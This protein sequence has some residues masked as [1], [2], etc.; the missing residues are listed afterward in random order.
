MGY[1]KGNSVKV[2]RWKNHPAYK[3]RASFIESGK[4][5]S[6]GFKTKKAAESWATE[7]EAELFSSGTED[8]LT[9]QERSAVLEFRDRIADLGVPIRE[10]LA[11]EVGRLE[12]AKRSVTVREAVEEM[13]LAP[14][15]RTEICRR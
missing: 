6:K 13:R 7:K 3:W 14:R 10:V 11:R 1:R 5:Q 9:F 12:M 4:Y 15:S 8:P 2:T